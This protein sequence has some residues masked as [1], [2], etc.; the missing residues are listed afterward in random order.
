MMR[1]DLLAG[2]MGAWAWHIN[3]KSRDL[4]LFELGNVYINEGPNKFIEKK[5]LS[6]A[7]TGAT[8][9]S[10][11]EPARPYNF[12]DAKGI[13]DELLRSF[14]ISGLQLKEVSDSRFSDPSSAQ[15]ELRGEVI[16]VIGEVSHKICGNFDIKA[17][18][19][20]AQVFVEPLVKLTALLKKF[21]ELPKYPAVTRDISIVVGNKITNGDIGSAIRESAGR[22]LKRSALVDKY[23]GAQIPQDKIGLTYRL[24]YQDPS[25][26]LEEKEV[27]DVHSRVLEALKSKFAAEQR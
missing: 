2:M 23:K 24:E 12:Y 16:G 27:A 26:T 1:P 9:Q 3:R 14:G 21:E 22:I 20:F 17:K 11:Q 7:V 10:W 5:A 19:Y 4:L 6:I 25:K 15:V 13:L 18:V 8:D